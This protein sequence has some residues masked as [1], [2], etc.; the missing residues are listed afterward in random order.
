MEDDINTYAE[1]LIAKPEL[2]NRIGADY[3]IV[4]KKAALL[5]EFLNTIGYDSRLSC[6]GCIPNKRI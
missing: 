2:L 4:R 1:Y 5:H 3:E 6:F